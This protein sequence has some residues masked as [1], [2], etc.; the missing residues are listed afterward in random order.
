MNRRIFTTVKATV[1]KFATG[2]RNQRVLVV[3]NYLS[4]MSS[5]LFE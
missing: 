4:T 3:K 5:V 1:W 2:N